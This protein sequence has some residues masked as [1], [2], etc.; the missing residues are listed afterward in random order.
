MWPNSHIVKTPLNLLSPVGGIR[1]AGRMTGLTGNPFLSI[2]LESF[3]RNTFIHVYP[4]PIIKRDEAIFERLNQLMMG[5][6]KPAS[7]TSGPMLSPYLLLFVYMDPE[8]GGKFSIKFQIIPSENMGGIETAVVAEMNRQMTESYASV[9]ESKQKVN[10]VIGQALHQLE[11]K[12][13]GQYI[14]DITIWHDGTPYGT[15]QGIELWE[16]AGE[17]ELYAAEKVEQGD[18]FTYQ[19]TPGIWSGTNVRSTGNYAYYTTA[20]GTFPLIFTSTDNKKVEL[21]V[22]VKPGTGV[23]SLRSVLKALLKEALE[24]KRQ[25]IQDSITSIRRDSVSNVSDLGRQ[26]ALLERGNL[27]ME[28]GGQY[29]SVFETPITL[30]DSSLFASSNDRRE[31]FR[32][33]RKRKKLINDILTKANINAFIDL[34]FD[35]PAKLDALKDDLMTQSGRLLARLIQGKDSE[36]NKKEM[37]DII[38]DYLNQNIE[39]LAVAQMPPPAVAQ[40]PPIQVPPVETVTP[41]YQNGKRLYINNNVVFSGREQFVQE[42][43]TYLET[44]DTPTVVAINYSQDESSQSYLARAPGARPKGLPDNY[45]YISITL[46]NIPG[47]VKYQLFSNVSATPE[48]N[49]LGE[50]INNLV[51]SSVESTTM[52]A[53]AAVY[54]VAEPII[55]TEGFK[56]WLEKVKDI[57]EFFE[58]CH[59]ESWASYEAGG[60]VPYCFWRGDEGMANPFLSGIIDQAYRE[61]NGTIDAPQA[62]D[63]LHENISGLIFAYTYAYLK[64]SPEELT[65]NSK[66]YEYVL[67]QLA[68]AEGESGIWSWTK[69]LWYGSEKENLEEYFIECKEALDLR[70]SV[71]DLYEVITD[72]RQILNAYF[73]V[74]AK[75]TKYFT[76]LGAGNAISWYERG[77]L[78]LQVGS[79]F[80]GAGTVNKAKKAK[81]VLE[82]LAEEVNWK[83]FVDDVA[84]ATVN[85]L[86]DFLKLPLSQKLDNIK[87][88]WNA[89]YP[90]IFFE[91]KLFEDMMGHYRYPKSAGWGHTS[92]IAHNFKAIDFYEGYTEIGNKIYASKAVSMKTTTTTDVYSWLKPNTIKKNL[93]YL[94]DGLD[95]GK[96]ITWSGKSIIYNKVEV[97]IYMSK[98]KFTEGIK[99]E[100]INVL[101][102]ERPD[103][104]FEINTLEEFIN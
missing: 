12:V 85:S 6:N 90:Q 78:T 64:C 60:V 21:T 54:E 28:S 53:M 88:G 104:S 20:P 11:Q 98:E 87:S 57:Y 23:P 5:W 39:R 55:N 58:N 83:R 1:R 66:Q 8:P 17:A 51:R 84:K 16:G 67:E 96:G 68:Q 61:F 86:D 82:S 100:W 29:V 56:E 19:I 93:D 32:L 74:E 89:S 13:K 2:M 77:K 44:L 97:H 45:N 43:E 26:I 63:Q 27:T 95:G 70:Q 25:Q 35:D 65:L 79:V 24:M 72:W 14:P 38:I 102:R 46:V 50:Q 9:G 81:K 49:S 18:G 10:T 52:E 71:E 91:R 7:P 37:L 42:M 30:T 101:K 15:G 103:I 33:L 80:V 41:D 3:R 40:I 94:E 48:G 4:I 59:T 92:D 62:I 36:G 73:S 31:G 76:T 69:E 47:S 75:L 99:S 22:R 34:V